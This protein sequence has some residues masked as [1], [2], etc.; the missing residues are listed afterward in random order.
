MKERE[1]SKWLAEVRG[2]IRA[3]HYSIR[4]KTLMLT[5]SNGSSSFIT[6][7]IRL[8]WGEREVRQFLA[9]LAV[10]KQVAASTQNQ[11]LSA[12]LFLYKEVLRRPLNWLDNVI[13]AKRPERLP[14]V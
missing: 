8:I 14:V 10:E 3:K 13:R 6:N 12:I 4:P 5:G 11:A 9:Y 1:M 7:V 2:I